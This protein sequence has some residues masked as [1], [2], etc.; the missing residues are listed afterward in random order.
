MPR[1]GDMD[2]DQ[3]RVGRPGRITQQRRPKLA[4]AAKCATRPSPTTTHEASAIRCHTGP[5]VAILL[6]GPARARQLASRSPLHRG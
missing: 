6:P 4:V 2:M 3:Q 1:D 5:A